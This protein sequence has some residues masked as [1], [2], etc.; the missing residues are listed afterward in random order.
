MMI[1]VR[2]AFH[3]AIWRLADQLREAGY[4]ETH[5]FNETIGKYELVTD[6]SRGGS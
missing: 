1:Y 6:A 5:G 4:T 3:Q 2:H